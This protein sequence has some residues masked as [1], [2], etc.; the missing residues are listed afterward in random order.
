MNNNVEKKY[1]KIIFIHFL[2][3]VL[4]MCVYIYDASRNES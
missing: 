4:G 2:K 3:Y 1:Q